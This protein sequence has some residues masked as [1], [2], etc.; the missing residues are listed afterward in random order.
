MSGGCGRTRASIRCGRKV[1]IRTR[2]TQTVH[3]HVVA[4]ERRIPTDE[5]FVETFRTILVRIDHRTFDAITSQCVR[6]R[7]IN[8]IVLLFSARTYCWRRNKESDFRVTNGVKSYQ[9]PTTHHKRPEISCFVVSMRWSHCRFVHWSHSNCPDTAIYSLAWYLCGWSGICHAN[10][11]VLAKSA[12]EMFWKS[13]K[14]RSEKY[15]HTYLLHDRFDQFLWQSLEIIF[16][17]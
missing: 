8:V 7:S 11:P 3:W 9:R 12:K 10:I 1:F 16:H 15:G 4:I 17:N 14:K 2:R 5:V 13:N 6:I